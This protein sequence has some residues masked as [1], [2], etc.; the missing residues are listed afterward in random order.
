MRAD[1]QHRLD[2][3]RFGGVQAQVQNGVVLLTGQV[4]TLADKMDAEKRAR[5][6]HHVSSV[7]DQITVAGGENV[8]D[9]QLQQKL[10][11]A[12]IY[13]RV[14]YG[15]TMFNA[16]TLQ[17]HDGIAT[18]GGVVVEPADKDS[19]LS[20]IKN[21]PGVRGLVDKVQVAPPS[22]M[23]DRVRMDEARAIYG[24][25]QLN[26]YAMDPAKP[27][28]ISVVNGHV[29]LVGMVDNRGDR[30]IAGIKANGVPGVFS[31]ENDLQVAGDRER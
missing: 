9:L 30:D 5:K 11:K 6:A 22:P 20:L 28:R 17:V 24:T 2:G 14:G 21:T 3:K 10:A 1:V 26:R 25:P 23:D 8:S 4:A 18:V 12:L 15:T 29:T 16:L 31:V 27:I 7:N 13:D 19:A